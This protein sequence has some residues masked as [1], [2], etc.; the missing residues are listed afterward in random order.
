MEPVG[1]V[2]LLALRKAAMA[3][4]P[5]GR[6]QML[7]ASAR[8]MKD[9]AVPYSFRAGEK[10]VVTVELGD[11]A[12]HDCYGVTDGRGFKLTAVY[13]GRVIARMIA[14]DADINQQGGSETQF[15]IPACYGDGK[16]KLVVEA[17]KD[18]ELN[19]GVEYNPKMD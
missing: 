19:F 18:G 13:G 4:R 14:P 11:Y 17:L 6:E 15:L 7:S 2:S 9:I 16:L 8:E 1:A 12:L 10:K 3:F 5:F